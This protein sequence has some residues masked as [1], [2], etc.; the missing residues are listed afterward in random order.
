MAG[1]QTTVVEGPDCAWSDSAAGTTQIQPTTAGKKRQP[2]T[3]TANKQ[4]EQRNSTRSGKGRWDKEQSMHSISLSSCFG[5]WLSHRNR[6][7]DGTQGQAAQGHCKLQP[8]LQNSKGQTSS[9]VSSTC[10]SMTIRF[11]G[12]KC[13]RIG[14]CD[15][16]TSAQSRLLI[17]SR[18]ASRQCIVPYAHE[19]TR[20][21]V[22]RWFEDP[23]SWKH[24]IQR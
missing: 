24:C 2:P 20:E 12:R 8:R 14:A 5:K 16:C 4:K 6:A 10:A 15:C 23:E 11:S 1:I 17:K 3:A 9:E 7:E 22:Q 18:P 19:Q 21:K 13:L